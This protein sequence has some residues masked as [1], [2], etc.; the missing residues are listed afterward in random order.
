[1]VGGITGFNVLLLF[2]SLLQLFKQSPR[3]IVSNS[4]L[5]IISYL[6]KR[7]IKWGKITSIIEI[8]RMMKWLSIRYVDETNN[9][10]SFLLDVNGLCPDYVQLLIL[11][12]RYTN[13]KMH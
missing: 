12:R 7:E 10:K 9:K 4:S 3:I 8:G 11:I 2:Y 6:G 13:G 1:M 5:V